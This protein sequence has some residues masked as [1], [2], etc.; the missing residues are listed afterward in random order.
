MPRYQTYREILGTVASE[1]VKRY[2]VKV[3][4]DVIDMAADVVTTT[5]KYGK[6]GYEYYNEYKELENA[7]SDYYK[8]LTR[9]EN[10]ISYGISYGESVEKLKENLQLA[11]ARLGQVRVKVAESREARSRNQPTRARSAKRGYVNP[12]AAHL[13]VP[14]LAAGT[15]QAQDDYQASLMLKALGKN[16]GPI[17]KVGSYLVQRV[18]DEIRPAVEASVK[19]RK[20]ELDSRA[21]SDISFMQINC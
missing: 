13:G 10:A 7:K 6:G 15:H 19:R 8:A 18:Q 14:M 12:W 1:Y 2:A 5:Y 11:K 17:A 16:W 21:G 9:Y 20:V 3:A 4:Y